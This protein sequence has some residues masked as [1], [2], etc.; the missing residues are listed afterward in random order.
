MANQN[1]VTLTAVN[2]DATIAAAA[3]RGLPVLVDL[4]AEWCGPCKQIAPIIDQVAAELLGRA[5]IGK[6]DVDT[7]P[8]IAAR[9]NVQSV[10]TLLVFHRGELV[11]MISGAKPKHTILAALEPYTSAA[12]AA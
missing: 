6:L 7:S 9:Y 8:A 10:P 12:A 4:W 2:F 5:V 1:T 11:Q 3:E